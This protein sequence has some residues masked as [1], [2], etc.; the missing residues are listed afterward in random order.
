LRLAPVQ[1]FVEAPGSVAKG[2]VQGPCAPG[3][4]RA[5]D[6]AGGQSLAVARFVDLQGA[7]CTLRAEVQ[8]LHLQLKT[9]RASASREVAQKD[10]K[11]ASLVD[12]TR[13]VRKLLDETW[14]ERSQQAMRIAELEETLAL[15]A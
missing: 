3:A 10:E 11:I 1:A 5:I 15:K 12:R 2:P 13:A 9:I 4:C 8:A 14:L 7:F 6:E